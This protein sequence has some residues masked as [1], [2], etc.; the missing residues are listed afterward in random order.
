MPAFS[1][2]SLAQLATCHPDLQKIAHEAIKSPRASY[3]LAR[4]LACRA[5]L[6]ALFVVSLATGRSVSSSPR[7]APTF[8]HHVLRVVSMRAKKYMV[9][10]HAAWVV[11]RMAGQ[12]SI[13]NWPV[14]QL[15]RKPVCEHVPARRNVEISVS[16][17]D[18]S[19]RPSPTTIALLDLRPKPFF[20]VATHVWALRHMQN[21]PHSIAS[22]NAKI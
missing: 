9:R 8:F 21:L 19:C 16:V 14:G 3:A 2:S 11:A 1:P 4:Q 22:C 13:S 18:N 15:P 5:F 6:P 12:Q 20:G 17:A 10:T 7:H